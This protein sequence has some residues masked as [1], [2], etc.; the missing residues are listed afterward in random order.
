MSCEEDLETQGPAYNG[1]WPQGDRRL[2][3]SVGDG[4]V[5]HTEENLRVSLSLRQILIYIDDV[6]TYSL[7]LLSELGHW[8]ARK[9]LPTSPE[10]D[11]NEPR[12]FVSS[13]SSFSLSQLVKHWVRGC[14]QWWPL[15]L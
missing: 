4:S 5:V 15:Y 6:H 8:K 3:Q 14:L 12:C 10:E 11:S 9:G 1:E 13:P 2:L 7:P